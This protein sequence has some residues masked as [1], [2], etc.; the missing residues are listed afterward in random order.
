MTSA[1]KS[2]KALSRRKVLNA[3]MKLASNEGLSGVSMRKVAKV[4]GVE[5]MSLYHHVKNKDD[6]LNGMVDLILGKISF[7]KESVNWRLSMK[8]RGISTRR[9]LQDHPWALGVLESRPEPGP[10]TLEYHDS[11]L[12][13]LLGAGFS[14]ALAG[15][16]FSSLDAY[17][18]GFVMQ[19]QSLPFDNEHELQQIA[20]SIL[21]S[22][23]PGKYSNLKKF[24][25]EHVLQPGYSYDREFEVGLDLVLDSLERKFEEESITKEENF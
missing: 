20:A 17:T 16:A 18:Y 15:H 5:P 10:K 14:M 21:N 13:V 9:I 2:K 24:T 8:E 25:I 4:L 12:G 23:P 1:P 22:F 11:V 6:I 7:V 19:E 3:A